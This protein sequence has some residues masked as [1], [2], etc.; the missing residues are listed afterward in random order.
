MLFGSLW[1]TVVLVVGAV[2]TLVAS[3]TAAAKK[4]YPWFVACWS[5]FTVWYG[6]MLVEGGFPGV[7]VVSVVS[8][9]GVAVVA[10]V[11]G[12][13]AVFLAFVTMFGLGASRYTT[14]WYVF[15]GSSVACVAL[16]VVGAVALLLSAL[17]MPG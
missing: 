16:V 10:L 5:L 7:S 11:V 2:G 15:V 14:F 17:G 8:L 6:W 3:A 1:V 9:V 13:Y 4:S 12:L